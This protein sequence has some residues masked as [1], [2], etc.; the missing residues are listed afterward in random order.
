[1]GWVPPSTGSV[2][3]NVDVGFLGNWGTGYGMVLRDF[4]GHCLWCGVTQIAEQWGVHCGEAKAIL[5]ALDAGA[6][7][8]GS[9]RRREDEINKAKER[10]YI[11]HNTRDPIF[12]RLRYASER[13]FKFKP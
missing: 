11:L 3:L 10:I 2:K 8:A 12:L 9:A 5:V 1:M 7:N 6:R 4:E 13:T